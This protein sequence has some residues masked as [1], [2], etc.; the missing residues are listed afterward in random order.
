MAGMRSRKPA[1]KRCHLPDP[2]TTWNSE[3]VQRP[4]KVPRLQPRPEGV[5]EVVQSSREGEV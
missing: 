5:G 4:Q 2:S 3:A 1:T